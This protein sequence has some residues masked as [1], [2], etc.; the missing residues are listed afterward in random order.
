MFDELTFLPK[1]LQRDKP[2]TAGQDHQAKGDPPSALPAG[3]SLRPALCHLRAN[4]RV[5]SHPASVDPHQE[6]G[7]RAPA[8]IQ[9]LSERLRNLKAIK[10]NQSFIL[11]VWNVKENKHL[12]RRSIELCL[13]LLPQ[14]VLLSCWCF[15]TLLFWCLQRIKTQLFW[16]Y[17][18]ILCALG[19]I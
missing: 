15:S 10:G 1:G 14:C 2:K 12:Q 19:K 4:H 3:G 18:W 8:G 6:G 5:T 7:L 17:R 11:Q 13:P 16:S 9:S